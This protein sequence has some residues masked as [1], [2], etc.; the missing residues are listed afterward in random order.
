MFVRYPGNWVSFLVRGTIA[1]CLFFG[2][3]TSVFAQHVDFG[4]KAGVPIT[5]IMATTLGGGFDANT[6]RYTI[7]PVMDIQSL[8][9]LS[10]EIGAMYKRID[11]QG[12]GFTITGYTPCVDFEDGTPYMC[13]NVKSQSFSKAGHSWEFPVAVQYHI[14]WRSLRPYAEG[15]VS[16]NNLTDILGYP[17]PAFPP[18][19][20]NPPVGAVFAPTVNTISRTGFLA[21][22]GVEIKV[23][24]G[25]V[26]P[27]LRYTRYSEESFGLIR[28]KISV[29]F[30]VKFSFRKF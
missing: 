14:P 8:K 29:D 7:G 25:H 3:A 28:S 21:G 12:E 10:I 13:A 16:F 9:Q 6:K 18:L 23:P 2:A 26:T 17:P 15:G 24:F 1:G 30:V 20:P 4:F 5:D 27:G 11:Q 22:G 19:A